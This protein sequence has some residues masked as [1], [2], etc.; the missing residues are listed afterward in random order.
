MMQITLK[1]LVISKYGSAAKFAEAIGWSGRKARD[2]V[3][4]RQMPTAYD[5]EVMADVLDIRTADMFCAVFFSDAST[6]WTKETA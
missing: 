6:K 4:G 3:S 2:I 1:G 5:M